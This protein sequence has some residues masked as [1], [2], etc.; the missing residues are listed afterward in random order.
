LF[1]LLRG[2]DEPPDIEDL[3]SVLCNS[4]IQTLHLPTISFF[5]P[6]VTQVRQW[7]LILPYYIVVVVTGEGWDPRYWRPGISPLQQFYSNITSPHYQFFLTYG[8]TGQTMKFNTT[9]LCCWCCYGGRM[10]PRYWIPGISPSRQ[11]YSNITS[12]NSQY[13][14]T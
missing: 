7:N 3:G 10:S 14:F 1:M 5:S 11:F 6:M 4:S 2:K 9:L 8:H 13:V 12:P